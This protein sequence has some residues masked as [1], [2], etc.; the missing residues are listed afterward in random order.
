MRILSYFLIVVLLSCSEKPSAVELTN[1]QIARDPYGVPHIFAKTD[2]EVAYGLAWAQC[3][4]Q[5]KTLQELMAACKGMLGEI[6]GKDGIVADFGIKFMGLQEIVSE[7]YD[8]EVTGGFKI[9]LES[10][11]AGVNA[12]A[13]LHPE[14][15]LLAELFPIHGRDVLV[16][17]LLGNLEVSHA[18]QDLTKILNGTIIK[19]LNS[20][21]P[22]GSNAIAISKQKTTDNKTYLAINSHQPL[23]G[24]YS[25]YEAHLV[26]EEGL[27]ILGGTFAGGICIFHGANENL[28]W[29]HTVNHAD[30]S[31]VYA[32][33]MHPTKENFYRFDKEWLQLKEKTYTTWYQLAGPIKFPVSKT[34]Y[35]SVYGPTFK[36]EQGT[37]AWSFVV[38]RSIKGAEQWLRMNKANNF[39]AF[40]KAL[41]M[42]GIAALNIV[43]ADRFDSIYYLSNGSF[44][45]R[46]PAYNWS[47]VL[48]GNTSETLWSDKLV[49]LDSLPQVL[50]PKEGWVFNTNNTPYSAT[51]SLS[52]FKETT[53]NK[54]MGYQSVGLENNR[55]SRFLELISQYDSL[56]YAD[57][58]KIKYDNQYPSKMITPKALNLEMLMHLDAKKYPDI[59][60]AISQLSQWNRKSDLDNETAALFIIAWL[61]IDRIRSAEGR[62]VRY[63]TITEE[64]C[65]A[66]IRKASKELLEKYESLRVPLRKVQRLIRGD[67]NMPMAGMPDVLAAMYS[68]EHADGTYKAFAG[69]SYIELV[70]FGEHGVEIESV[71]TYGSSE[72]P[73]SSYYTSEM[74][75]FA[76]QQLKK[77]TLDKKEVL[78]K[79]VRIYA[80]MAVKK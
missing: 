15:V 40:K 58:K 67:I 51:D 79:A 48:P 1:I 20:E 39:T 16:G 41:E 77:M 62:N 36:T 5:F 70:R 25:W 14:E 17:Y 28:A 24:W 30:F 3:E 59:A 21:A 42:R 6:K 73:E 74:S 63:G 27:N 35:E 4:D 69:E 45:M 11:V 52:N 19:D 56:S 31:D 47:G 23:E 38:G 33:E 29:A 61:E 78:K 57:F 34:I 32:L 66:G 65:V 43:Y 22:K 10:F 76:T 60:A 54:V 50:N 37:F 80:P 72:K 18:G 71:N 68:K 64:D 46:N 13:A 9:Y 26:S 44:P 7:K 12:Y 53:L 8:Q 75:M 49:S 2:A 55:S